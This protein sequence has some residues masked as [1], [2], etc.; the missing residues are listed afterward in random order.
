MTLMD[1]PAPKDGGFPWWKTL[2]GAAI[3]AA[4]VY[5]VIRLVGGG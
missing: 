3:I 1:A 5:A 2:I 4:I